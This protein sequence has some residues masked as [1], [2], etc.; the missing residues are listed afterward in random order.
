MKNL[1]LDSAPLCSV[2]SWKKRKGEKPQDGH[3]EARKGCGPSEHELLALLK[4]E[5]GLTSG[6]AEECSEEST[7]W[8]RPTDARWGERQQW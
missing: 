1:V 7:L 2:L 3:G 5:K 6:R 4:E 8:V